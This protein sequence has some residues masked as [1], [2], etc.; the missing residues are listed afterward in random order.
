MKT[1]LGYLS[2]T[3]QEHKILLISK[4]DISAESVKQLNIT[5]P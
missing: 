1:V 5:F 4:C 2:K 3:N